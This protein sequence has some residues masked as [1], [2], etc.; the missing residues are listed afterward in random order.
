M[1][2]NTNITGDVIILFGLKLL[3]YHFITDKGILQLEHCPAKRTLPTKFL[4]VQTKGNRCRGVLINQKF[5]SLT[6]LHKRK[7]PL[8]KVILHDDMPF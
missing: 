6:S 3:P 5:Y 1:Q 8:T 4:A 7:Y 2:I